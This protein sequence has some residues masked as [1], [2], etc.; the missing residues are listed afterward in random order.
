M[1]IKKNNL[2]YYIDLLR[3]DDT[4]QRTPEESRPCVTAL[5]NVIHTMQL[6]RH[7]KICGEDFSRLDFGNIPFNGIH[8]SMNGDDP[9]CFDGCKLNELNFISGHTSDV[10]DVS[11]SPDGKYILTRDSENMI[12]LWDAA[13]GLIICAI[14]EY[15]ELPNYLSSEE[16]SLI[17]KF[18]AK[19]DKAD[20]IVDNGKYRLK[21]SMDT[22][23]AELCDTETGTCLILSG[24]SKPVCSGGFSPDGRY[25]LTGSYDKTARIWDTNSGEC[26]HTLSGHSRTVCSV[27][28]S[29]DGRYC[30][31]GSFDQTTKIWDIKTCECLKTLT[32]QSTFFHAA[33]RHYDGK[34]SITSST[35]GSLKMW[36][37]EAGKCKC[38]WQKEKFTL[39]IND[40]LKDDFKGDIPRFPETGEERYFSAGFSPDGEHCMIGLF[41]GTLNEFVI[42][43]GELTSTIATDNISIPA[44]VYSPDGTYSLTDYFFGVTATQPEIISEKL[45]DAV[46]SKRWEICCI[47]LLA[48]CQIGKFDCFDPHGSDKPEYIN[49]LYNADRMHITNCSFKDITADDTTKEIIYQYGETRYIS[50][51]ETTAL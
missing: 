25:C 10:T 40:I 7:N 5:N 21:W 50:A 8:W 43:T 48:T 11:W 2:H 51:D 29:P 12:I 49:T 28:F 38:I 26:L 46:G 34:Y 31:T 33:I 39:S 35:D 24:H 22:N 37:L 45:P 19:T 13:S 47:P 36:K 1:N 3:M 16:R 17:E 27:R 20:G 30:L 41:D 14:P 4:K 15:E 42:E 6:S 9:S 32:G 18:R 44:V 23:T